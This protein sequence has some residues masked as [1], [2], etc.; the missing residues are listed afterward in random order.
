MSRFVLDCSATISWCF[1]DESDEWSERI[2][3]S[4]ER[5]RALVPEIWHLEVANVLIQCERKKRLTEA[6]TTAFLQRLKHFPI[7]TR[8]FTRDEHFS[9]VVPLARREG[10]T[11]YDASYLQLALQQG[12]PL[13]A[14]DE[15]LKAAAMR[16]GVPLL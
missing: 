7:E 16:V 14:R 12:V 8:A 4:L 3:T 15:D 5:D 10:L 9:G 6:Q 2:L 11:S 13:A 1:E